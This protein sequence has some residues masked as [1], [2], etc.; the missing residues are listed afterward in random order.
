MDYKVLHFKVTDE[1]HKAFKLRAAERGISMQDLIVELIEMG[2][3]IKY[4]KV[5]DKTYIANGV[6]PVIKID[7][8]L[9]KINE[10]GNKV[11]EIPFKKNIDL[12]EPK[13]SW[14][15]AGKLK[16]ACCLIEGKLC[17][18]WVWDMDKGTN[19]NSITG[20]VKE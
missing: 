7:V 6:D 2:L 4:A 15:E 1:M 14:Q 5:N 18:H 12:A 19:I 17:K 20:E 9:E 13:N 11:I 16:P 3:S 8:P 10:Y